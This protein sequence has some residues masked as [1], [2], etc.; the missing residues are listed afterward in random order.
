MVQFLPDVW[1]GS[2]LA[3][4]LGGSVS[5]ALFPIAWI[6]LP[7]T[8]LRIGW[9]RLTLPLLLSYELG[10][11]GTYA[12]GLSIPPAW[13]LNMRLL[14]Q[15][16]MLAY[17]A[18]AVRLGGAR[19]RIEKLWPI[20]AALGAFSLANIVF[21]AWWTF[22]SGGIGDTYT[23]SQV[24][25]RSPMALVMAAMGILL[26]QRSARQDRER[27][28]LQQELAAAAE[29][30]ALL[31][32][33]QS[34][35]GVESVYL[36][37]AE[38]GG[39]FYQILDRADG[40]W[41]LLIGDVSGK[42]LK[43][44]MLVSVVIGA[45]R[46]GGESTPGGILAGLNR[47]LQA[48]TGG[49]FVTALCARLSADGVVTVANAGHLAPY[50]DGREAEVDTGLPLGVLP[51]AAYAETALTGS[52]FTFVTD[53]VVEAAN[54]QGELFGFERTREMSRESAQAIAESARAWGQ[55]DDITVV[56]VRRTK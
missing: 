34:K 22:G 19:T 36:P 54:A 40:S 52:A 17:L 44:A 7:R 46:Q 51:A 30:Q 18:E 4:L 39:D 2:R 33:S 42:G 37:A 5:D 27:G 26:N 49:G 21:F 28:R 24:L 32:P 48:Q 50:V 56:T 6:M 11:I 20:H 14:S 41:I 31:V 12:W 13:Y 55:N 10:T 3:P 1:G 45:V 53:G 16:L 15:L 29:V 43:A 25:L 47:V 8:V 23:A 9:P 35:P 38:V